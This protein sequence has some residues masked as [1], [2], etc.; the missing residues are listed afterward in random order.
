MKLLIVRHGESE[1]NTTGLVQ[2]PNTQSNLTDLGRRQAQKLAEKLK[3]EH[4]DLAF[5]SPMD[6]A[7]Q[8]ADIIL[9]YH[10]DTVVQYALELSERSHG[11]YEGGPSSKPLEDWHASG[12]PFGEFKPEGGESWFEAGERVTGFIHSILNRHKNDSP[13]ILIVGHGS[14]FTYF[15]MQAGGQDT[16][17][18]SKE[19]YDYYHPSNTAMSTLELGEN[20]QLKLIS[21]N[22][23]SHL[24]A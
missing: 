18:E 23:V 17:A 24:D 19:R 13:T 20:G 1:K 16:H 15:L 22:N 7:R 4:I 21:L 14:V 6:R 12:L 3:L 9:Q 11:Q 5:V 2:G 10:P 8:T